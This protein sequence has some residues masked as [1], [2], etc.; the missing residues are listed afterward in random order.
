M[1][2]IGDD[3]FAE[4]TVWQYLQSAHQLPKAKTMIRF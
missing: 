3:I 4:F 2:Q 1:E